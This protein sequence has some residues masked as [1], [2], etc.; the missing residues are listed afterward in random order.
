M[1]EHQFWEHPLGSWLND[2]ALGASPVV[3]EKNW[4]S[5]SRFD[6]PLQY[7]ELCDGVLLSVLFHQIDP[8]SVE[9]VSPREVRLYEQDIR[10]KQRLFVA[11]IDA[12]RRLYKRRL[13]QLIVVSP[14]DIL[15]IVRNPRPDVS[16]EEL[17]KF[18][19]LL[20]GCA[21]QGDK[22]KTFVSRITKLEKR[23]Q[24][25]IAKEI[26][27][28][29][30]GGGSSTESSSVNGEI[31]VTQR[32]IEK[33][34]SRRSPSPPYLDRHST[35]ELSAKNAELR[36]LRKETEDKDDR[37]NELTDEL[38]AAEAEV[39]RLK[40]E[41]IELV[42]DARAAKDLRDELDCVQQKLD[43]LQ[44]L[45]RE[46]SQ[47]HEK[48]TKLDYVQSQLEHQR[49]DN[50]TLEM[51]I[52]QLENELES[53][54][55]EKKN[56]N[57]TQTRLTEAQ[58]N[59]RGLQTDLGEKNSR[60]E[61]LLVEQSRLENELMIV[62]AKMLEMERRM[63]GPD[64]V[65]QESF[66]SLADEMADSE[67]SE[68][69]QL[70][71]ENRKLR[72]HL[73][74]TENSTVPSTEVEQLKNEIE[75][76]ERAFAETKAEKELMQRQLQTAESTLTQ[77]NREIVETAA[78]REKL[79]VERDES[80]MSLIDARKK[81]A[82]F[83]T[84]FGRKFEQE[85]Q[86]KV[87][88]VEA[89]LQELR[90]KLSSV[91][92]E[93]KQTEK[94]LQR[95]CEEQKSLRV[96]VD[97]LR[98]EKENA[99]TQYANA[100][101]ARRNAEAERNSLRARIEALD[102][103]CEELRERS[104]CAED[105][106]RRLSI[107]ERRV[108]ELQTRIG[109]LEAENRTLQ[110][111]ME[112][113]SQKIQRLREDLVTEKSK[114]AELVG[115]LRSVCAAIALNGG[116]I[117][118]EM[119]DHQL[120]DSIDNV[121]MG[122]LTAAK[123]EADALRLQQH[124]QIAELNDLKSD[125]EKLRRSESV[126]LNESDDRVRE[127][128]KENVLLK[129]QVFL[130]QEKVRELQVEVAAK[131]SEIA[132][133]KRGIEELSRNSTAASASNTELAR[134]QVSLRNLQLQ[135]EL[136]R[137]DNAQLRVQIDLA[138][139]SRIIAKK[140]ADS[141]AAMHQA[142]L[143]D[144]DRLQNLHDLLTHDYE[145][146]RL[147][148]V[149][150]KSKLKSQRPIASSNSRDLDEMRTALEHERAERD[151]QLRAFADL[152]NE[153][154]ALK[155]ELDQIRQVLMQKEND[156][157]T[158]N[159][160]GLGSEVR[161][162]KLAEQA[163]RATVEDLMATVE[164]QSKSIQTKD[165]EIAR[166]HNAIELLTE[167]NRVYEE[168]SK[169]LG[170]Q[171]ETLLHYNRE[172]QEKAL[173]EKNEAHLEQKQ[174]QDRLNALQRHKEKLEEK[175]MD[176]YRSME[177][178]KL[179][180]RQK[181]PLVKRAAKALISRRRP[182]VPSGGSTTEDSSVYSADEGSPP[183]VNGKS[184][185]KKHT[186]PADNTTQ[187]SQTA[188]LNVVAAAPP[189]K[190]L[191]RTGIYGKA[192]LRLPLTFKK[193]RIDDFDPFPPTCSSSE[194]HDR[195]TPPHESAYVHQ[196]Q[197]HSGDFVR[198]RGDAVGGSLRDYSPRR[199]IP[200]DHIPHN[201]KPTDGT[202]ISALPPRAP[203]RNTGVTASL[204]SRPPPPPYS[205]NGKQKPPPYPGRTSSVGSSCSTPL[206]SSFIPQSASTPKSDQCSPLNDVGRPLD[207]VVGEGERRTFVREKEE[208]LDKAMS[209]YENVQQAEV[210]A[211]EST[212]WYEYGCV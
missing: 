57:E 41:R 60:I 173:S 17:N 212:V 146:A 114:G 166:L 153:Q 26:Q 10:A 137:E 160:D 162:L 72:S 94:Q 7:N 181:Q 116:K 30:D 143:T 163:Q 123:R 91:K 42:K 64:H 32:R 5:P 119:D 122:A 130:A 126:S 139:K 103:E 138:E 34:P 47:L 118:M 65:P 188:P 128:S 59:I 205:S 159:C 84:E 21:V 172:L 27:K 1:N 187:V 43:R 25:G 110:Q 121:I 208:R 11:L 23:L 45:E 55:Q 107:A 58:Q 69:M 158:R 40:D 178:K 92:E 33:C 46:N 210:R 108:A 66:G 85:A 125:I 70:R 104:R 136:L 209:I 95:V 8:S 50:A 3:D 207:L 112:L 154:G 22:K 140:D 170:R 16:G 189:A 211:N 28:E 151:R 145:R 24:Q 9:V 167:V 80:V 6:L 48:L 164:E 161:K 49:A 184:L 2:V 61:E 195:I 179:A 190:V 133:A 196:D 135:E 63:D 111:Q 13:R 194:D 165:I 52:E 131:N 102:S 97:E 120:I 96:T 124:T 206:P 204:R 20:L 201:E 81:F 101:R 202:M 54:R 93:R 127:L 198:F 132:S 193:R 168:E 155:R 68:M 14:P 31:D 71:L 99:E 105:A 86:A 38:E 180:E 100:E 186:A 73:E 4:R 113:E 90:R 35:V 36:K 82:Q 115:R 197:L 141:L 89:E 150:M 78:E 129:E 37:I 44:K 51:S 200:L 199:T 117:D 182:S 169:N 98:E 191:P 185:H 18:V 142:L 76:R 192:S 53:L 15:A 144:H 134:L 156:C 39:R 149:D 88:E 83:Q 106:S 177:S 19:L 12:I 157:L 75:Q 67:R 79:R 148:N 183:L 109:D 29:S 77:L 176:Q 203:M 147:E 62:N 175:I 56:Q 87:M 174:F 74:S 171:V 152:H